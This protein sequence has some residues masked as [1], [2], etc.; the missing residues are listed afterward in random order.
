M[1]QNQTCNQDQHN[2]TYGLRRKKANKPSILLNLIHSKDFVIF[3]RGVI[4]RVKRININV[5]SPK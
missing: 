1:A 4:E 2:L 5:H 3:L